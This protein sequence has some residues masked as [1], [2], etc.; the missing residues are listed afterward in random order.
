MK[1]K[2][3]DFLSTD[4]HHILNQL[5]YKVKVYSQHRYSKLNAS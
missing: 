1:E 3:K 5:K 2:N 4:K